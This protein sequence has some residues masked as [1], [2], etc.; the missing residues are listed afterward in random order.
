[1]RARMV[2]SNEDGMVL[3]GERSF[4]SESIFAAWHS[5]SAYEL[6][7]WRQEL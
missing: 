1:V 2:T 3:L 5:G 4:W 7:A 6:K